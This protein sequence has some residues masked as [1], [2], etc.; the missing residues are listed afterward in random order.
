MIDVSGPHARVVV[1]RASSVVRTRRVSISRVPTPR[2]P[3]PRG[4]RARGHRAPRTAGDRQTF[5]GTAARRST[6]RTTSRSAWSTRGCS[7]MS[8]TDATVYK[9]S[10]SRRPTGARQPRIQPAAQPA[11]GRAGPKGTAI[12]VSEVSPRPRR[13]RKRASDCGVRPARRAAVQLAGEPEAVSPGTAKSG[14]SR[15]SRR[16]PH[17]DKQT[18]RPGHPSRSLALTKHTSEAGRSDVRIRPPQPF[19]RVCATVP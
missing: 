19:Y 7:R 16:G 11:G 17:S 3:A 12:G 15:T 5:N 18:S 9:S 6:T 8:Q 2:S 4:T 13:R 14:R 10:S 1:G